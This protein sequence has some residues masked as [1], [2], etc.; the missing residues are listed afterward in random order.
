MKTKLIRS[1]VG[2]YSIGPVN[3]PIFHEV[4]GKNTG[5][6][7][8]PLVF[9]NKE[10]QAVGV[11]VEF[12]F[13]PGQEPHGFYAHT[14]KTMDG[15]SGWLSW[16]GHTLQDFDGSHFLPKSVGAALVALGYDVNDDF[17]ASPLE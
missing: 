10:G 8:V 14:D 4:N 5:T 12:C 15:A 1:R 17:F 9:T 13:M 11:S 16:D 2:K 3:A 7:A 6:L